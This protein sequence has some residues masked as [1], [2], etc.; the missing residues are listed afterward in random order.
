MLH[1]KFP[2]NALV[3]DQYSR[4][5]DSDFVAAAARKKFLDQFLPPDE[6]VVGYSPI[7]CDVDESGLWLSCGHRR[8]ECIA[9]GDSPERLR[10][11]GIRY[12]VVHPLPLAGS[13]TNWMEKY[14]GTLVV[15]YTFPKMHRHFNGD[16]RTWICIW[17][18]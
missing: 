2:D 3:A 4:Y 16:S 6:A 8:V 17:C 9:P 1:K 12:V 7:V 18:G 13:I 14:R 15:Q 10:S 5:A 11:L